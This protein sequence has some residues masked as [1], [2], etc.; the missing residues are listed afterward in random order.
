MY[1]FTFLVI[2]FF[3]VFILRSLIFWSKTK[4]NPLTFNKKD[5]AH[6]YNGKI[7]TFIIILEL[8]VVSIYAFFPSSYDYLLPFW[9]L[10][11]ENMTI[12]GWSLLSLSMI[13]VC[14]AQSSMADSWRIGID[15]VNKS[16]LVTTG[17]FSY[18]RN[19]IFL[20]IIIANTG[21]VLIIPN[22]F[23]LLIIS[24]STICINTQVRLEEEFLAN[25]FGRQ[26]EQYKTCV[27]R[28]I[29]LRRT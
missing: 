24:L 15:E 12:I 8:V 13:L 20:G 18:T 9:Y 26:Y 7:F 10:E 14:I 3:L 16:K 22:A 1:L 28:W 29:G 5:D 17:L 6:G 2:Y 19:P 27:S 11:N 23:T 4:I 25:K 21:L